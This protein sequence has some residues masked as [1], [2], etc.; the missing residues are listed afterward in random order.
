MYLAMNRFHVREENAAAFEE[1]WLGRDSHLKEMAGFVRFHMLK[2]PLGKDGIRLYAS[3]TEWADE[4]SFTA[5]TRSEAF[6][7]AHRNA[8][9]GPKL[10][11]GPPQFE[12]F[13]SVQEID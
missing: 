4:A 12:G 5:W 13:N 11:E 6:R 2:G 8:G 10:F 1:M 3:H 7:A 9:S